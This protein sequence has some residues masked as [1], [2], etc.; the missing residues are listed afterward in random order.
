MMRQADAVLALG[1]RLSHFTT[2]Y[3][4]RF[5]P[6][7]ARIVQVEIDEEELGRNFPVEVGILGD[8]GAA[9]KALLELVR[10]VG[11]PP[12]GEA[13]LGVAASLRRKASGAAGC[14]ASPVRKGAEAAGGVPRTASDISSRRTDGDRGGSGVGVRLRQA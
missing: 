5:L 12:G 1:T 11:A 3:D 10:E 7:V 2:F 4:N 6:R 13:R 9:S 8:V 14:G